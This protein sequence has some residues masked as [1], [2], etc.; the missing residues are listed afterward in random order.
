M[1]N[2]ILISV[3]EEMK[4]PAFIDNV[5]DFAIYLLTQFSYE[6][7]TSFIAPGAGFY[8]Q[9][10]KGNNKARLAYCINKDDIKDGIFVLQKGL[11]AYKNR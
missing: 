1:E 6:N 11:E 5:E 8:M 7:K 3:Q 4:A 9:N 2:K 10:G